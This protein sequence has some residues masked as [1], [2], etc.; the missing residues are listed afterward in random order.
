MSPTP[1]GRLFGDDLVLTR[2]FRAPIDDVWASLTEPD[3]TAR[4]FGPWQ[5]DAAPGRPIKVQM[6]QEEDQPWMDMTIDACERPRRL[7][8]SA[9][10]DYGAWHLDLTL[11]ETAGVTELRFTQ[12]LTG[13][14]SV[15]EVGP[16]WEYYLDLLVASRDGTPAPTFDDYYPA[17]K[18]HFESQR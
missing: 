13:K 14:E 16:G 5:G 11:T 18:E 7:A 17:M 6:A 3:R 2:T 4:W 1:T 12:H 9:V 8:L 15:G 10:D